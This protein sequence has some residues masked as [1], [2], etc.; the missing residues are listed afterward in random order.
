MARE[1][2]FFSITSWPEFEDVNR[3]D[4]QLFWEN[5]RIHADNLLQRA[6]LG[7]TR[8]LDMVEIGCG[9]GRM[10]QR[11]AE[12]FR[13]VYALDISAEMIEQAKGFW[14][15]LENVSFLENSG[16]DL[17]PLEDGSA[18]FVFSFYVLNHV[19]DP[20]AVLGYLREAAR[21]LRPRGRALLHFRLRSGS[22][23]ERPGLWRSLA[24]SLCRQA[25]GFWWNRGIRRTGAQ[26]LNRL[27]A[28]FATREAWRGSEVDWADVKRVVTES[29]LTITGTDLAQTPD[30]RFVF[31]FLRRIDHYPGNGS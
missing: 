7:D 26:P 29:G 15:R 2:A 6:R 28:E 19:T 8:D 31:L 4:R 17:Q 11:F 18:D 24:G 1:N 23:L 14:G 16:V 25:P 21:V 9:L 20:A 22:E 13:R 3:A 12:R 10:T 27:S 5:G 30:T